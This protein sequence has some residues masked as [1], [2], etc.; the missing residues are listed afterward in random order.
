ME[1]SK[2]PYVRKI[3][4]TDDNIV[5]D[6]MHFD[7]INIAMRESGFHWYANADISFG[8]YERNIKKAYKSGLR[9]VL[10]G[11]ESIHKDN[12]YQL[13]ANN[14]KYRSLK[15]YREYIEKIQSNGI[16]I[17]GSFIVGQKY[18]TEDTFKQ[19]AEFIYETRLYGASVTLLTPY[20]GTAL[21]YKLKNGNQISTFDWD[22]YTIFQPIVKNKNMSLQSMNAFY[23]KLLLQI[24]SLEF[25]RN[26]TSYFQKTYRVLAK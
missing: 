4:I 11:F 1:I 26:K 21:F 22:Y 17:I 13:D 16:G 15:R 20:P 7:T 14:F 25:I 18:D 19:L 5:S 3:Y 12:L 24:N 6:T 9:Q 8:R 10:I 23:N 2:L